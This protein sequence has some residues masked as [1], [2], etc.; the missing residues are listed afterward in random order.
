[1][2]FWTCMKQVKNSAFEGNKKNQDALSHLIHIRPVMQSFF[3]VPKS[4][5][6]KDYFTSVTR[7]VNLFTVVINFGVL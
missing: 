5:M 2:Y 6:V 4:P 1:M 7:A 3:H